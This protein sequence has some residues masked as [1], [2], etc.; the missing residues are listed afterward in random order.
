MSVP[1][2]KARL[3]VGSGLEAA[4]A[5]EG[6]SA[7]ALPISASALK[8]V[9]VVLVFGGSFDPPHRAHVEAVMS[10]SE[11]LYGSS[12][13]VLF[14]PAAQSPHKERGPEASDLD[15]EAML[16]LAVEGHDRASVWAEEIVRATGGTVGSRSS[17]SV[18]TVERLRAL[19]PKRIGIRLVMGAD[20]AAA[21]HRW[22]EPERILMLADPLVLLREP[23]DT[24]ARLWEEMHKRGYWS[25][26]QLRAWSAMIAPTPVLAGA[27]TD[28]RRELRR[29]SS[30]R[31]VRAALSPRVLAYIRKHGLYGS[32]DGAGG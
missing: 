9:R 29:A 11:R 3:A 6:A 25:I 31:E 8:G 26:D 13:W 4:A 17:Y 10:A 7:R 30:G 2:R 18:T 24:P 14:V 32:A 16:R 28:V 15:R 12:G 23:I 5:P 19:L 27:S 1:K 22:R 21:F 20:Q